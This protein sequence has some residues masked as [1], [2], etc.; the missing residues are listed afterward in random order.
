[1]S[2]A[3]LPLCDVCHAQAHEQTTH[4]YAPP[5]RC[6]ECGDVCEKETASRY[7]RDLIE[8]PWFCT[9]D[10][11]DKW[12]RAVYRDAVAHSS[13]CYCLPC[14]ERRQEDIEARED[15]RRAGL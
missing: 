3:S 7:A 14:D 2:P 1:M 4:E 8:E 15:E 12:E 9:E 13:D 6:A 10:C 5:A 11:R